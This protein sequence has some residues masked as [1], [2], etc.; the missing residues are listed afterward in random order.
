MP[1]SAR[2]KTNGDFHRRIVAGIELEGYTILTPDYSV[3]RKMAFHR[4]GT[5]EKGESFRRDSSIGTEYNSRPFRTIRE[6]FFLL[7]AGLRKYNRDLYRTKSSA[8]GGRQLFL[9][10]GWRD[11]FAGT[12][13][14]LSVD[15]RKLSKTDAAGLARH[16]HDHLPLLIAVCANSPVWAD[17]ITP[18]ASNRVLKGSKA[19]FRPIQR[20]ALHSREFDEMTLNRA[21]ATKPA[22]LEIRVLDSNIPEYIMVAVCLAKACALGWLRGRPMTNRISYFRYLRS[23]LDAARRGMQARLCWNGEWVS[24]AEYLNRF[25]WVYRG[26]FRR[27]DIPQELWV[28]FKLLKKGITGANILTAASRSS[29]AEHPQTWQQRF[30]RRYT[31]ALG[32]LLNGN[33]LQEFIRHLKVKTPDVK[34]VWLGRDRLRLL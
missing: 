18:Y 2:R 3:S 27:M 17:R 14:H 6:G 8:K 11:R 10:G 25:V 21:R 33:S 1:S 13:I 24:A 12:H 32:E 31:T 34:D 30:A 29:Y 28:V 9:V 16:L 7:K 20:R 4:K 26:E 15:G 19:Y 5:A 23:R 22:T